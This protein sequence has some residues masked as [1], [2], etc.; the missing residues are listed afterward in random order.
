MPES[1]TSALKA[2]LGNFNSTNLPARYGQ[3]AARTLNT[4][5]AQSGIAAKS[6]KMCLNG[7]PS[8]L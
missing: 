8:A 3:A 2:G 6:P 5:S 4:L 1:L 7:M